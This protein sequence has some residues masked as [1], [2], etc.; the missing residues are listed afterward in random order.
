MKRHF[1]EVI[2][3]LKKIEGIELLP[4]RVSIYVNKQLEKLTENK[5]LPSKSDVIRT[6]IIEYLANHKKEFEIV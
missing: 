5:K 3:Y 6:A 4:I 1:N 2:I